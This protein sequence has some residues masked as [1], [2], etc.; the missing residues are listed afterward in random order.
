MNRLAELRSALEQSPKRSVVGSA[1]YFKT[2]KGEYAEHDKFMGIPVPVLRA[3]A[4][5]YR[6][7]SLDE[8]QELLTSPF[9]EER[10]LALFIL[11]DQYKKADEPLKEQIFQFYCEHL[12]C[13]N[14]WNLVDSSAPHILG[15]YIFNKDRTILLTLAASHNMWERRIAIVATQHF[16]RKHDLCWTFKLAEMLL[17]D[18]HDLMHKATGWMLRE[19]GEK[20]MQQLI[21]FLD[22]HARRMPRTML[23]YAIEKFPE[24]QRKTILETSRLG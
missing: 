6:D 23:R 14:N 22:Q 2:G 5:T 24:Q 16:I 1:H 3:V 21:A 9:N 15:A 13:V 12:H 8:V 19:A 10:L 18:T 20:D 11:V 7:L 17:N 4:K